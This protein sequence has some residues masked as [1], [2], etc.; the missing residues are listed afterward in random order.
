MGAGHIEQTETLA[1]PS[2]KLIAV[3]S[4]PATW[5]DWFTIH[6]RWMEEP[7]TTLTRGAKLVAK[8][9]MLGM[10][11]K[12][13]WV[14]EE[15]ADDRLVLSGAGMAGVKVAFSFVLT[16]NGEG[17]DVAVAGD[18]EGALIKGALGKAVEKDGAKQI[19]AS[20]NKLAE[21]AAGA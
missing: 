11:N 18:F 21:L 9:F 12:I 16:P 20:L 10:A 13:D 5:G 3:I 1:A 8:I 19:Q 6:E 17:A 2:E 15:I 4:D 14:V 7:P